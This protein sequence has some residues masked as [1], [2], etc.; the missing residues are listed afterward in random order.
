ATS[1]G[2]CGACGAA[3]NLAHATAACMASSCVVASCDLGFK[4]C[5]GQPADG[6]ESNTAL[7]PLNCGACGHA[8]SSTNGAPACG[9]G[10]CSITCNMGFGDCDNNVNDGCE[11]DFSSS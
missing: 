5:D 6:C 1:V 4:D 7:D 8:C 3:C 11:A 2:N 10:A 9:G